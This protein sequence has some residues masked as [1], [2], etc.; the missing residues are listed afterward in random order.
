MKYAT[1]LDTAAGIFSINPPLVTH[2]LHQPLIAPHLLHAL[3]HYFNSGYHTTLW[4][5]LLMAIPK[6]NTSTTNPKRTHPIMVTSIWYHLLMKL[7]VAYLMLHLPTC[8]PPPNMASVGFNPVWTRGT[9]AHGT[10]TYAQYRSHYSTHLLGLWL[11]M[12]S[13]LIVFSCER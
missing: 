6:P 8:L 5:T 10:H 7:F 11:G 3:Q 2:I 4:D 1:L 13:I 9:T 12:L